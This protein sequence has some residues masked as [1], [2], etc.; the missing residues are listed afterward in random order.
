MDSQTID[1]LRKSLDLHEGNKLQVY[2][3]ATGKPLKKGDT[4][5]GNPTIGRG[6]NLADPGIS[7][8][9]SDYL[10]TNDIIRVQQELDT[11]LP[12]WATKA[13]A[14]QLAIAEL[15][16]N[17]GIDKFIQKWPKTVEYL[18][19]DQ[20]DKASDEIVTNRVWVEEVGTARAS[21]IVKL[22]VTGVLPQ[23]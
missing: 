1:L 7:E 2:D 10:N 9:E 13:P 8:E 6:R 3:D 21:Y 14:R 16:F 4:L 23:F 22:I 18:R 11:K 12:W 20:N 5:Q 19:T 15:V 17:L